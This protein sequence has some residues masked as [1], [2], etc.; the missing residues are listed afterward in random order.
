MP[1]PQNTYRIQFH[2]HFNF[3]DFASIISYL[4]Q[5]GIHTIYASPI[6]AATPGST[7]GYDGISSHRINPEIGTKKQL[8]Q[9][10]K[11][12][13]QYNMLWLQDIVP[14]HMAYHPDNA[15]LMDVLELGKNS[16]YH[17]YFDTAYSTELM[18]GKIMVPILGKSLRQASEAE[19]LSIQFS[20][21][22]FVIQ[23][24]DQA[25]P[26]S[27]SSYSYI[28]QALPLS[29]A[30]KEELHAAINSGAEQ[31]SHS[32]IHQYLLTFFAGAK[33]LSTLQQHLAHFRLDVAA[34]TTLLDQQH[35]RLCHW[36]ET[37]KQINFRRFFTVNG[38]ICMNV[39]RPEVFEDTHVLIKE[40][41]QKNIFD[42]L[43]IDHIDGLYNPSQ[44]L[45]DLRRLS[46]TGTYIVAEKILESGEEL[47]EQWPIQGATGYE[48]LALCNNVLTNSKSKRILTDY[49]H[50]LTGI[51]ADPYRLQ[52]QKKA[53]IL[54]NHMGGE[55]DNL[56][57][58][59]L[60]LRLLP[61]DAPFAASEMKDSIAA[62]LI[63][64]PVYRL[65]DESFPL[66]EASQRMI[67][68]VFDQILH[69]K[70]A[71]KK[72]IKAFAAIFADAQSNKDQ[73]LRERTML[74]FARCMQFA[75]PVM[76]KGVEDTLMYTYHRHIGRHEVGDHPENFGISKKEFHRA[77]A[78]RQEKWPSAL[79]GSATHDT[80]RGEDQRAR[81]Q[82]L[83]AIPEIWIETVKGW[84]KDLEANYAQTLPHPNDRYF[85]FQ[86]LFGSYPMPDMPYD[87]YD[88]RLKAYLE[89]YLRE[90][91]ERSDWA[92]P[93]EEYENNFKAF[94]TYLLDK[95]QS[96]F[97]KF[98]AFFTQY[99]DF[100]I[101]NSLNQLVLKLTCPGIPDVYQGTELWELGFVDPD[102]RRPV[103]YALRLQ[104]LQEITALP[105]HEQLSS[106][107]Q[108]R[109]SG[110]I[111]LGILH[112]LLE[113][114]AE[115]SDLFRDGTYLPI[116]VAG[117]YKR[118]VLAYARRYQ[119]DWVIVAMPLHLA[120]F[121]PNALNNITK[122]DWK[123]TH[124]L[125]PE[126]LDI[127]WQHT[128][129]KSEGSSNKI[130]I[131]TLFDEVPIAILRGTT[132]KNKRS[133]GIVMH[134]TSLPSAYGIGD[135]GQEA[136]QFANQLAAA[137]QQW[138]QVLPL[139]PTSKDQFHSPYN[140]YSA[141]A[142]N[143][144]LIDLEQITR[145]LQNSKL[146][147]PRRHSDHQR[148]AVD[149]EA[150]Y[151]FKMPVLRQAFDQMQVQN[152]TDFQQFCKAQKSWLDDYA[153]FVVLREKQG[154]RPWYTW[155]SDYRLRNPAALKSFS[156]QHHAAISFQKW[157][158]YMFNNQW[159]KLRRYCHARNISILGDIPIYVSHDSADV[160]ANP[161]LF[162]LHDDG[163]I[164]DVAGVPPDYF[165]ADGQLWGMPVFNWKMHRKTGFKW[166]IARI[167]RNIDLFDSVRLDHFRAFSAYWEVP[168]T[169]ESAKMGA[170]KKA[171]GKEL[172]AKIRTALGELPF[173]AE[174]LGDIDAEVYALRD[175]LKMPGMKV[176][177]F[178]FG[179]DIATSPHIPHQYDENY[180][181]YTGT[182]D[183]NTTRGW[184]ELETDKN[185]RRNIHC[186]AGKQIDNH[187]INEAFLR[188]AYGSRAKI[189]M[190][191]M[192]DILDLDSSM[193]MNK[194]ATTQ[195]NWTWQMRPEEFTK[196]R[197][198]ELRE[199]VKIFDRG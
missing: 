31:P 139:G 109:Y 150:A 33:K 79:N 39:D 119:Q 99:V 126:E 176:L 77:M 22:K 160:W 94:A 106:L 153:L 134:I 1:Q 125:L 100:G 16:A 8:I 178:A 48:F 55:I 83:S 69:D 58:Y 40:L 158:Q 112:R 199:T 137:R 184:Y 21:G 43:R 163:S 166:W 187:E 182:H 128:L 89:K 65:Y 29:D 35:Y 76:A 127:Q 192:Q 56:Y 147:P 49:Y 114:R 17:S 59:L 28:L 151:A 168:A 141:M 130:E 140:T 146:S 12:L 36:Q 103:D 101:S 91:K 135:L 23:Y 183:N 196:R 78:N 47:S 72:A 97:P 179:N 121:G 133:A 170:W 174:D 156:E 90:G 68:K 102:N 167:K 70:S 2:Q 54:Q 98:H 115:L 25:F 73:D 136:Y 145:S 15:W 18:S 186:Y 107:W 138:W 86:T 64:F 124:I 193:R 75:G 96:F 175:S 131:N 180:V 5:L 20:K 92:A 87:D 93:N 38:L 154:D 84:E 162:A 34:M 32:S 41:L 129:S 120:S 9:L 161:S 63:Y 188:L 123:D 62:F 80:K 4:Q 117:K 30:E 24:Y 177:Q 88:S 173:I 37:D 67:S 157:L 144:L 116:K 159:T 197:I 155:D 165:N 142:G 191:P 171:L 169:A 10:K 148:Q 19:E 85:L 46:G 108:D 190:V 143:P 198:R 53:A 52:L 104:Y 51:T 172:F 152:C 122:F 118:K 194:P 6:L 3:A 189:A 181:V 7:H 13:R 164:K 81:L 82:V 132:I 11:Q 149:F 26:L 50:A 14:N 27:P 66:A 95:E 57:H 44:Y 74:F 71:P 110:K 105:I 45:R 113:L 185:M 61:D 111:K 195:G 60:H 42:G